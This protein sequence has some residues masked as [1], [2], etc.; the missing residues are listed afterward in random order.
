MNTITI[1]GLPTLAWQ[2]GFI[3][4]ASV[5]VRLAAKTTG[6]APATLL[7][8]S[9]SAYRQHRDGCHSAAGG[10]TL[11]MVPLA[12]LL[13]FKFILGTNFFGAIVLAV[14]VLAG[15]G[16]VSALIGSGTNFS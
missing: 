15:C 2:A 5:P 14:L 6:A 10:Q 16:A 11:M 3:V 7:R 12:H 13:A 1:S 8:L 9:A 4:V